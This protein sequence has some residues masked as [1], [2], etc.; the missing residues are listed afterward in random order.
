MITLPFGL[1]AQAPDVQAKGGSAGPTGSPVG[2]AARRFRF[3]V[4]VVGL[5]AVAPA[6]AAAAAAVPRSLAPRTRAEAPP[7]TSVFKHSR[8]TSVECVECHGTGDTHGRLKFGA[9]DGCRSCHHGAAQQATCAA[10]HATAPGPRDVSVT[11]TV[12]ARKSGPVTRALHFRHEQ[13]RTLACAQCHAADAD[14]TVEK[15]CL[16]CHADHHAAARDCTSCHANAR[17]GHDRSAH[18]GCGTCHRGGRTPALT[19]TRA[20]CL[21]CHEKQRSH[22]PGGDCAACHAIASHGAARGRN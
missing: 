21:T 9:P 6:A 3:L 8:H 15:T 14:R 17:T 12:K 13:H 22:E 18:D 4:A 16:S 2:A 11:F 1:L 5:A 19:Y 20:L 10:C 7:D